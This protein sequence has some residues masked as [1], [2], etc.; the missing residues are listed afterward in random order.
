MQWPGEECEECEHIHIHMSSAMQF[1]PRGCS[2]NLHGQFACSSIK[3]CHAK[4]QLVCNCCLFLQRVELKSNWSRVELSWSRIERTA[5]VSYAQSA[6]VT[7][8]LLSHAYLPLCLARCRSLSLSLS[9]CLSVCLWQVLLPITAN[10]AQLP[11][12]HKIND[13]RAI[14]EVLLQRQRQKQRQR[15]RRQVVKSRW[16]NSWAQKVM[17]Q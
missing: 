14:K 10:V 8:W 13:K 12:S 4:K 6:K 7:N 1:P 15:Q 9:V 5:N 11:H 16:C 3:T 17:S 2:C